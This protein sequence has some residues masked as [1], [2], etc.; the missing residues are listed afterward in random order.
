MAKT[1]Q[2]PFTSGNARFHTDI[3]QGH[4]HGTDQVKGSFFPHPIKLNP[5][6][7]SL[8]LEYVSDRDGP[9]GWSPAP[10]WFMWYDPK[11]NPTITHSATFDISMIRDIVGRFIV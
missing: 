6:G 5:D 4:P 1:W 8:W 10:L 2:G 11:G 3:D 9:G 7:Y